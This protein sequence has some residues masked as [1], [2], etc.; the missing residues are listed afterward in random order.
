MKLTKLIKSV[1]VLSLSIQVGTAQAVPVTEM[2][3]YYGAEFYQT[4]RSGVQNQ[5]LLMAIKKVLR[6]YHV[7]ARGGMDQIV[8]DCQGRSGCYFHHAYG[9]GPAR[10]FLM[11]NFYLVSTQKGYAVHDVYCDTDRSDFG[12]SPP[13]PGQI[14]NNTVVNM[15]H[16]WPQSHFTRR[17]ATDL[18]KSDMHHLFPTDSQLNAI[19][20]NNPFGEVSRDSKVLKCN[21]SRYGIGTS[22]GREVFEPP[23]DHKGNVARAL[24]Y[25]STRYDL[26]IDQNEERVLRKWNDEDPIDEVEYN[27]NE[28]IYK[29]Q[30]NRNPFIDHNDLVDLVSDF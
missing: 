17:F 5:D 29:L 21:A 1:I 3:P 20:G 26:S 2:L 30:G 6:S 10:V 27:R 13:G 23:Q 15:E 24:F 7:P 18:Q 9:Y 4:V 22:G 16:T 14:P 28:E 11:G 12:S 8:A 25:F 19:R